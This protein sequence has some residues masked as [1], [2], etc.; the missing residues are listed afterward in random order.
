VSAEFVALVGPSGCGKTTLL[1]RSR[2][3]NP[4]SGR[5]AIEGQDMAGAGVRAADQHGS[6]SWRCFPT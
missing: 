2:A 4:D 6:R 5:I 3:E 1:K